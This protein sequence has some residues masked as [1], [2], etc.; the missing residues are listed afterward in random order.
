M[1]MLD[2]TSSKIHPGAAKLMQGWPCEDQKCLLLRL[3]LILA[4][5]TLDIRHRVLG[6]NGD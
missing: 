4:R 3:S 2:L 1:H 5:D 6:H